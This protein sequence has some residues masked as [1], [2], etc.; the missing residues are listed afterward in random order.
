MYELGALLRNAPPV[1]QLGNAQDR[2]WP[3]AAL[4]YA[5]LGDP[6]GKPMEIGV[7]GEVDGE[8][9]KCMMGGV[10]KKF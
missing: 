6:V 2:A 10:K 7:D 5:F 1:G 8:V 3:E 9:S 4:W